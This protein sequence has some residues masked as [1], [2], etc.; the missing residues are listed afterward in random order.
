MRKK[1][2]EAGYLEINTPDIMDRSLGEVWALGKVWR[3]YVYY[4]N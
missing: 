1:Q 3:K 4:N 2:N